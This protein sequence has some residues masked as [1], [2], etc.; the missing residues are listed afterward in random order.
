MGV[1]ELF[2]VQ[3]SQTATLLFDLFD[4]PSTQVDARSLSPSLCFFFFFKTLDEPSQPEG[5]HHFQNYP[6]RY[7]NQESL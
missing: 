4:S 2:R 3:S 5:Y 1:E 7:L 6:G